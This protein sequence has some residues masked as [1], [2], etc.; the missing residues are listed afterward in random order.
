[1]KKTFFGAI[2]LVLVFVFVFAW[3]PVLGSPTPTLAVLRFE[4]NSLMNKEAYEGLKKGLC[5]M[6]TSELAKISAFKVV[7]RQQL[8]ALLM[9][10]ELAQSDVID[11]GTSPK[12]GK[13]LGAEYL[14]FGSFIKDLSH[15]IRID[16]RIVK[17]ETGVVVK[18]VEVTGKPKGL[19][20]L[21]KKLSYKIADELDVKITRAEKNAINKTDKVSLDVLLVYSQG[22][23]RLDAGDR[24]SARE[25]FKQAVN[26]DGTFSRAKQQIDKLNEK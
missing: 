21:V 15:K 7:E 9:E 3:A 20:K 8:E 13:L 14:M 23:E 24:D 22:L 4:N 16:L 1:M 25:F 2:L 10:L 17:V 18:A 6:L 11:P 26:M 5:D 12:L 19:F